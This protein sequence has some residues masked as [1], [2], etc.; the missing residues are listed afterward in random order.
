M[1]VLYAYNIH[2][3]GNGSLNA[4]AA[5]IQ[6][7][8]DHGVPVEVFTRDSRD[9]PKNV[10]GRVSAATNAFYAPEGIREFRK[11]LDSFKPDVVHVWD[12]FPRISPWIFP[13]CARRR[14]AVVMTCDDYFV[15]C[16]A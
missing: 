7:V 13:M 6:A 2:R 16:P 14:I 3:G 8:R 1:R 15:T 10:W 5:S 11:L 4:T 9:L 12:V